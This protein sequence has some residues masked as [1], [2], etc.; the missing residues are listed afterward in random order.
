MVAPA[1]RG[2][3]TIIIIS[4]L[5][6]L[7]TVT[8]VLRYMARMKRRLNLEIDDYLCFAG[9]VLMYAM[10]IELVLWCTI[11]RLGTHIQD[12]DEKTLVTFGKIFFSNQI[13]YFL[14][15]PIIKISIVCFYRRI[16]QTDNFGRISLAVNLVLG[17]W[18]A[19]TFFVCALQCQP[20]SAFWDLS[21]R[22]KCIRRDIFFIVTQ[23][24][25]ILMDFVIMGLP[26]PIIWGLKTSWQ[27]KLALSGIFALGSFVCF[28]SIYRIVLI[29]AG[30]PGDAT[31]ELYKATL[32][33]HIEPAVAII[34]SC[35]PII[36]TIFPKGT[37]SSERSKISP[38]NRQYGSNSV[39][40][41][42]PTTAL[43]P[44]SQK[45]KSVYIK[46]SNVKAFGAENSNEQLVRDLVEERG[47][48]IQTGTR[49]SCHH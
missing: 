16:F 15:I 11:G 48:V 33:T 32:W 22:G 31:Y 29:S 19:G 4:V 30:S 47:I 8:T 43:A 10:Y 45:D 36:R 7:A 12:V 9:M 44:G 25:N 49:L 24:F 2:T 38:S 28:V 18:G 34:C 40:G 5:I 3:S 39:H 21:T 1:E 17:L 37:F 13:I 46:M 27:D 35:L 23:S 14:L 20:L 41:K 26:L 6:V 42:H